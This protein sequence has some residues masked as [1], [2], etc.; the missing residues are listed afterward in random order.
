MDREYMSRKDA[1]AYLKAHYGFGTPQSLGTYA[2][3]GGGPMFHKAGRLSLY[4]QAALDVWAKSRI[5]PPMRSTSE[6]IQPE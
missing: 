4:T 3:K 1:A 5:S 2:V 6:I